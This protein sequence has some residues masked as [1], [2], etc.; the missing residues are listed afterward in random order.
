MAPGVSHRESG[1][2]TVRQAIDAIHAI[3]GRIVGA[4]IVEYN[5]ERD[6]QQLTLEVATKLLKEIS[7]KA[8]ESQGVPKDY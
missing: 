6:I 2:L 3:P 7:G 1:G 8:L 5:P 4:D